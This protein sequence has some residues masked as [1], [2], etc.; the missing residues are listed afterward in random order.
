VS[1]GI[2]DGIFFRLHLSGTGRKCEYNEVA[3]PL[4]INLMKSYNSVRKEVLYEFLIEFGV[5][6]KLVRQIKMC[7]NETCS[8][9]ITDEHLCDTF[10]NQ[11]V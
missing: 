3:H 1:T 9:V 4:F 10:P 8:K 7:L 6:M 2:T 11:M 5:T